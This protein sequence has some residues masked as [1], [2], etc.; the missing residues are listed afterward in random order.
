MESTNHST[1][2]EFILIGFTTDP[3]LQNL[4]LL[5]F[6]S[7]YFLTLVIN[8]TILIIVY[9]DA[10]LHKPMYFL[11]ASLAVVDLGCSAATNPKTLVDFL[12]EEKTITFM[13]CVIQIFIFVGFGSSEFFLFAVM[14]F[15]R[16]VAICKPL[17][18]AITMNKTV[19]V[20]LISGSYVG[21]FLHSLITA[22]CLFHLSFCG[23]NKIQHFVRDLPAFLKLACNSIFVNELILSTLTSSMMVGSLFV[24]LVSYTYIV[25]AIMRIRTSTGRHRAFSTCASHF[26]CVLIFYGTI[27]F[28]YLR[29]NSSFSA[30]QDN[31]ISIIYMFLTPMLNPLIYSLRNREVKEA[32]LKTFCGKKTSQLLL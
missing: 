23:P 25:I 28:M 19:C 30:K 1:V 17:M 12:V 16:Y 22:A 14:A 20:W 7:T 6:S 10:R 26:T 8:I 2:T 3:D 11:L 9:A 5:L 31:V 29:P 13:G 4:L 18:Y 21:G 24:V 15:D 27:L 32:M